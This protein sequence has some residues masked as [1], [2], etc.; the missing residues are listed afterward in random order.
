M[1]S[2]K[3]LEPNIVSYNSLMECAVQCRDKEQMK[4]IFKEI[5]EQKDESKRADL[6]TFSTYIKGLF[7]QGDIEE[8]LEIFEDLRK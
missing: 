2:D 6:I 8:A 5:M 7:K 1:K 4:K 3:D